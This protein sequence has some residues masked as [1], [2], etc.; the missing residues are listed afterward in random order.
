MN[1]QM[2][3]PSWRWIDRSHQKDHALAPAGLKR[4]YLNDLYSVQVYEQQTEWGLVTHL[5]VRRHDEGPIRDWK[6]MQRIK[7]EIVGRDRCAVEVYPAESEVV[8]QANM[9]HL[10]VLPEGFRLPFGLEK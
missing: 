8:D 10:W 9:Y 1:T 6:H 3:F 2:K 4:C 5:M 7:N